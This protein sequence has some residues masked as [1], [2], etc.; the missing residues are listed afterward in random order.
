MRGYSNMTDE[1]RD[2][3]L[4]QHKSL[5]DGYAT[6]NIP[7][8]LTKLSVYDSAGDKEGITVNAKGEV[9]TYKNHHI[10]E[11]KVNEQGFSWDG[12][13]AN[14]VSEQ[15]ADDMDVSDVEGGDGYDYNSGGPEQFEPSGD[16]KDPYGMDLEAIQNMF[17]FEDIEG[18]GDTGDSMMSLQ[19]KMDG[20]FDGKEKLGGETSPYDFES[21]G[22]NDSIAFEQEDEMYEEVDEDLYESFKLQRQ[23]I[24]ETFN[25]FKKYN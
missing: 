1:E 14:E 8:N 12:T 21:D 23:S 15:E 22:P 2:S 4:S 9:S 19:K 18:D 6:G 16:D 10:N 17:D 7:T 3:I 20:E 5:Y 13:Y 24:L 11:S 25:K